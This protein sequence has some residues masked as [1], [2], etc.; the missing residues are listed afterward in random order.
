MPAASHFAILPADWTEHSWT[1]YAS[2]DFCNP[3]ENMYR[4]LLELRLS[5]PNPHYDDNEN[6]AAAFTAG[7]TLDDNGNQTLV[8]DMN[9]YRHFQDYCAYRHAK[10]VHIT[11]NK[12]TGEYPIDEPRDDEYGKNIAKGDAN[13]Y[14]KALQ[15]VALL[16][17]FFGT[18][19]GRLGLGP[20]F[21]AGGDQVWLVKGSKTPH[22]FRA[23]NDGTF[24]MLGQAYLHGV[25]QGDTAIDLT[26][27]DFKLVTLT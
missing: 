22:I 6:F 14:L 13:R 21:T 4:C 20:L 9:R 18:V 1:E 15:D 5:L 16:R 23:M 10:A 11:A 19:C 26:E 27:D 24:K 8:G 3:V 25:M 12:I 2:Y 17:T 7:V